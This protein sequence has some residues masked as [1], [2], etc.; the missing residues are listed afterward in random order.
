MSIST[1]GPEHNPVDIGLESD[2]KGGEE[3][4]SRTS[5]PILHKRS[6]LN[7]QS[8][9]ECNERDIPGTPFID[10]QDIDCGYPISGL[11]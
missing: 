6:T 2:G 3:L 8:E 5:L 4:T 10:L 11:D 9:I 7:E 1:A